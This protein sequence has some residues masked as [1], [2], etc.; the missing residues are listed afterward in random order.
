M[1]RRLA[2]ARGGHAPPFAGRAIPR[3]VSVVQITSAACAGGT[4]GV[5]VV[6]VTITGVR[7][8]S[9]WPRSLGRGARPEDAFRYFEHRRHDRDSA[10]IACSLLPWSAPIADPASHCVQVTPRRSEGRRLCGRAADGWPY[11]RAGDELVIFVTTGGEF[12]AFHAI[13][14]CGARCRRGRAASAGPGIRGTRL[15]DR[16]QGRSLRADAGGEKPGK[17]RFRGSVGQTD[18]IQVP[19]ARRSRCRSRRLSATGRLTG[20]VAPLELRLAF[21]RAACGPLRASETALEAVTWPRRRK[22][23]FRA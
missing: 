13:R 19:G 14:G 9:R 4:G 3:L 1:F 16:S 5:P 10:V 8:L 21:G 7:A 2:H 6:T 12:A 23:R 15:W 20:E 11:G 22:A 18:G 17:R